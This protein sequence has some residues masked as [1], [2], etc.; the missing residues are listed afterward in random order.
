MYS[1][2]D[3]FASLNRSRILGKACIYGLSREFIFVSGVQMELKIIF[4]T[5]RISWIDKVFRNII[6]FPEENIG[7][8]L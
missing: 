1:D 2:K 7:K 4:F 3:L 8:F 5:S 6:A